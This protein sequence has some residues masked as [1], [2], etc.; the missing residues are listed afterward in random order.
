MIADLLWCVAS[1]MVGMS[2]SY[3]TF[4]EVFDQHISNAIKYFHSDVVTQLWNKAEYQ[5][6]EILSYDLAAFGDSRFY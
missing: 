1:F 5:A 3:L 6:N 2:V 4:Q